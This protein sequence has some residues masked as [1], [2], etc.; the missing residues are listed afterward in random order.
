MYVLYNINSGLQLG[1][2]QEK[3]NTDVDALIGFPQGTQMHTDKAVLHA[4]DKCH[5]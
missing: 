4:N 1:A 3:T 5:N 2:V